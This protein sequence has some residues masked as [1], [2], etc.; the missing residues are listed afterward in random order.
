MYDVNRNNNSCVLN[1][2]FYIGTGPR[3]FRLQ[4]FSWISFTQ[5]PEYPIRTVSNILE[6]SRRYW[7]LKVHQFW[8][9]NSIFN[10]WFNDSAASTLYT[11]QIPRWRVPVIIYHTVKKWIRICKLAFQFNFKMWTISD[12]RLSTSPGLLEKCP[13]W[14]P[15]L[16]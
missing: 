1:C 16:G 2:S 13:V 10:L 4:V 3:D 5:A 11:M 9:S 7:K 15:G 12:F 8:R 14:G 6:Y